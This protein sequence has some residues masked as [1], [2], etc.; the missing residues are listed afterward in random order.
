MLTE[1]RV[2]CVYYVQEFPPPPLNSHDEQLGLVGEVQV[3]MEFI[4]FKIRI[5]S[6]VVKITLPIYEHPCT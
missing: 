3:Y 4:Q 5:T 2:P 6:M 1:N